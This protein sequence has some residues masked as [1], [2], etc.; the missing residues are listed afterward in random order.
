MDI[1]SRE[2]ISKILDTE[3]RY[4]ECD[5]KNIKTH[6]NEQARVNDIAYF[7]GYWRLI[8]IYEL[9]HKCKEWAYEQKIRKADTYSNG[10]GKSTVI[11]LIEIN[12]ITRKN[13]DKSYTSKIENLQ[14]LHYYG[15]P[16]NAYIDNFTRDSEL[17]SVLAVCEWIYKHS[18]DK[19]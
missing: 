13:D 9:A 11:S 19:K 10:C 5:V 18:K 3:V 17:E 16:H 4:L 2:L 14:H 8:N 7:D 6:I 1:I 12:I 15:F